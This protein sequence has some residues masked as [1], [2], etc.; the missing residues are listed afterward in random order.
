[1]DYTKLNKKEA[2]S[3][4]KK[5]GVMGLFFREEFLRI[6]LISHWFFIYQWKIKR[7]FSKRIFHSPMENLIQLLIFKGCNTLER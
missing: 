7:I 3:N 2:Y 5:E 1:M 4:T 6:Q